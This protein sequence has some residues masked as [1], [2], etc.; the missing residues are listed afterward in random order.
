MA[1]E[2]TARTF[3]LGYATSFIENNHLM[4]RSDLALRIVD[5]WCNTDRDIAELER[6]LMKA[7][8]A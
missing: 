3:Y 1:D 8:L 2:S 4:V 5:A 6:R 7:N